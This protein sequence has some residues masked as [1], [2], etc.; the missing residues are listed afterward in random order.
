MCHLLFYFRL[1]TLS[2]VICI[3]LHY[4]CSVLFLFMAYISSFPPLMIYRQSCLRHLHGLSMSPSLYLLLWSLTNSVSVL[5]Y[6]YLQIL[7]L[8][9]HAQLTCMSYYCSSILHICSLAANFWPEDLTFLESMGL[10]SSHWLMVLTLVNNNA[11]RI[12]GLGMQMTGIVLK[13]NPADS[14][15]SHYTSYHY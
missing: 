1:G 15:W 3:M 8:D 2:L 6:F 12:T 11:W 10:K 13:F 5:C 4:L 7:Y 9:S 14:K